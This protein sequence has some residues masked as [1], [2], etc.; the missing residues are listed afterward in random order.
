MSTDLAASVSAA[1]GPE[2]PGFLRRAGRFALRAL[3]I[4]AYIALL[5]LSLLPLASLLLILPAVFPQESVLSDSVRPVRSV[6]KRIG[7]RVFAVLTS[8][9]L[10]IGLLAFATEL[11]TR[12]RLSDPYFGQLARMVLP[13][14]LADALPKAMVDQWPYMLLVL[15]TTD[16]LVLFAIGKVPLQYNYRNLIVRWKITLLTGATFTLVVGLLT[17][18]FAYI[19]GLNECT[20]SSGIP[21]NVFVLS[22]GANDEVFSN[23]GHGDIDKLPLERA[24]VDRSGRPLPRD[25]TVKEV[26][27]PSGRPVRLCSKET[28]F[29]INQ[30][31]Q[32]G[33]GEK[34]RRKFVQVRGVEDPWV[35]GK[36]RNIELIEGEWRTESVIVG[37][38]RTAWE[39]LVGEGAAVNF[40]IE[41]GKPRLRVGDLFK[42]GERDMIVAGVMKSEGSTFS[43]ETWAKQG[44]L[45][46]EFGKQQYT[47]VVLR[48]SDDSLASADAFAWHLRNNFKS[49][50]LKAVSEPDYYKDLG[51]SN[52]QMMT[53]VVIVALIMAIGGVF[54]VMNTMFAAIAQRTR[55]IGVLRI[56]G[57]KRWQVLVSFMLESLG[58]ALIG[59]ALG[60]ALGS[61]A[62]GWSVTSNVSA[63][64][65]TFPKTV[66]ARMS[67]DANIIIL[68]VLFT[69][70]MGRLGGLVPSLSAMRK[71]I[72]D[73]LK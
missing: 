69:I 44:L 27:G 16:L 54:G 48:V 64:Q 3:G 60:C 35:A 68:G 61:I 12:L 71:G 17:G 19:N 23:L 49:P 70:V 72:L 40:G 5:G 56:L 24:S 51:K 67:V 63:G 66:I 15:Y 1:R 32:V 31:V 2:A 7:R 29:T 21:G 42:V 26:P 41:Q 52:Q 73:S 25:I 65:N 33:P 45:G 18:M 37:D 20:V 4:P 62:D 43:S 34:P 14:D 11:V 22:D 28:Y 57:F 13:N 53:V 8:F 38:G 9:A 10:L 59:G 46:Q 50:R 36:V 6:W 58:I 39:A 55:D 30:A 47:T